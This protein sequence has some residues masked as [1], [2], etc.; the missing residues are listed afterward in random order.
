[1][2][3]GKELLLEIGT[4][5]FPPSCVE[6]GIYGLK[7]VLE[8]KLKENRL[9]FET[10]RTYCSP[11]RL[12]GVV[13]GL[14]EKQKPEVKTV[15][16]PP[17]GIA[18]DKKG[19]P[20]DA[21]RGFAKSLGLNVGELEE[22]EIEGKGLYLGKR[23]MEEGKKTQ[24]IIPGILK[25]SILSLTFSKQ[26]TWADYDIRFV[27]PIRWILA[28]YDNR[29]VNFNIANL[30]SSN[31]TYGH[32]TISP[33]PIIIKDS[34]KYFKLVEDKG[35]VI[36]KGSKRKELIL[37]QIKNLEDGVW[38]GKFRVILDKNLLE[39][40]VNLV[41][42]PNVITGSFPDRFLYIPKELL[43]E[44]IQHHQKYFAVLDSSGNV[45]NYFIIVQNGVKDEGDVRKGNERVLRARLSDAAYFY[46]AD[47]KHDFDYWT[48]KL[49]GVIFFSGL[50]SMYDKAERLKKISVYIADL[51]K[52]SGRIENSEKESV[53]VSRVKNNSF[54]EKDDDF[55]KDLR[56]ASMLCKCDLVTNMV[57]EF[58]NLQGIVGRQ[59]ALERGE[60]ADV[61]DAIFEHYLPRFAG[62]ILPSNDIGLI[63]SIADKID[64]ITGMFGAG[65]IPSG[66]EDP[67]AL[68]RKA[69]GIVLSILKGKYDFNLGDI[70]DYSV[71]L[72]SKYPG[73]KNR[74]DYGIREEI[75]NFIITRYRF[76]IEK[77]GKRADI[78]DSVL[79]AGCNSIFDID[80]RYNALERFINEADIKRI[81]LPMVRCKNIINKKEQRG[82]V[83][84]GLFTEGLEKELFMSVSKKEVLIKNL[85]RS[86][87]YRQILEELYKL[88]D[89]VDTFFDKILIMD[90]DVKVRSNRINLVRKT[91]D[92]YM[93]FADFSKL[94][95]NSARGDN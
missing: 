13:E 68:R 32:R 49:K 40:V 82:E 28:L 24:D 62:D 80:L 5:E 59:Y 76:I 26:M 94:I 69:Q 83:N 20:T 66:S 47:K 31:V 61:A 25:D 22:I 15:T 54:Y 58:P 67:F 16:G 95:V 44:A 88:G 2:K 37:S 4:E 17:V 57:V 10:V 74:L 77:E 33:G 51:L 34:G 60:K 30:N 48:D 29:V 41:E 55:Y 14:G 53:K 52:E 64:T 79:G 18:L 70:I 39:D 87:D 23:I 72:F 93:M 38:K 3:T 92:L 42:I 71:E 21:A 50:G 56:K 45:S 63:L 11:R 91:V 43:I 8:N 75:F 65:K 7:K 78:L 19:G 46:E 35:K 84:P 86:K 90:K 81:I 6:E 73:F 1:M 9:E 89:V 85:M 27:R 12:V 36:V